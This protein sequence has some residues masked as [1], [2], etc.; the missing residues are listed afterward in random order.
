[1]RSYQH[2]LNFWSN[3]FYFSSETGQ[4]KFK[5]FSKEFSPGWLL[6]KLSSEKGK[7]ALK[8]NP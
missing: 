1:M 4:Y 3:D 6:H 8:S 7:E 5:I 2:L